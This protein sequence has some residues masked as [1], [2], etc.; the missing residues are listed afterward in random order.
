MNVLL[1]AA[2]IVA[3]AILTKLL[4]CRLPSLLLLKDRSK[5]MKVGIGMC[6]E[7]K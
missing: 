1:F 6:L 2:V 3:V 5:A 7:E 4:G